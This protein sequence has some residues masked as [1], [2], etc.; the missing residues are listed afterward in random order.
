MLCP[1][2]D[3][4]RKRIG[5]EVASAR[6]RRGWGKEKA[7]REAGVSAITWKKVEDG[8]P[9]HDA[10]LAVVLATVGYELVGGKLMLLAQT[11]TAVEVRP[12][13]LA[14][15]VARLEQRVSE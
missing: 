5:L 10:T 12:E 15:R 9:V 8:K 2:N 3:D 4:D 6:T 14:S 1:M 13:D 11:D 7:S